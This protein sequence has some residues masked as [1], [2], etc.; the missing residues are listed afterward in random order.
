MVSHL[1]SGERSGLSQLGDSAEDSS[2]EINL[3]EPSD[4]CGIRIRI[5]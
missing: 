1:G 2:Q 4:I 5:L 3:D